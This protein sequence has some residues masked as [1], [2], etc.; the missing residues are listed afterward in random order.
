MA[1]FEVGSTTGRR[2]TVTAALAGLIGCVQ[3]G[4]DP[5]QSRVAIAE[6]TA[7]ADCPARWIIG[8][9]GSGESG[10]STE[11]ERM[12]STV[13]AYV[14]EVVADL[15]VEGTELLSLPYPAVP[16]GPDYFSSV[17]DGWIGLQAILRGRVSE[18]PEIRI[19]VVGYSQ[20][21]H[22]VNQALHHLER[23]DPGVLA[24]IRAALLIADPR[25]DA[26]TPYHL[27][28]T[29]EGD[30]AP[31]PQNGGILTSQRLPAAL[32]SRAVSFCISGDLVCDASDKGFALLIQAIFAPLHLGYEECCTRTPFRPI[33]GSAIAQALLEPPPNRAPRITADNPR[34]DA[35]VGEE[36]TN[37]GDVAD[38]DG[39]PVNLTASIGSL[40]VT[41]NR[42]TWTHTVADAG[43]LTVE[44]TGTDP[45][46]L[47]T[48]VSFTLNGTGE[49]NRPPVANA[50]PD[51]NIECS[52]HDGTPVTLNG[53][54]SNDPDGDA[55][56][57]T[58][59]GPFGT[60]TGSAPTVSLPNGS[61]T[62]TLTVTDEPGASATDTVV[63]TVAD[64]TPPEITSAVADRSSLWPPNH[65]MVPVTIAVTATDAC[66]PTVTCAITEVTSDEPVDGGGD[67]NTSPDWEITGD[68]TVDLRAERAGGGDGR[69][70]TIT[71][72]CSDDAGN[73]ATRGVEVAV[74]HNR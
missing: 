19:A 57:F 35:E 46:G 70:Y 8:A 33:L 13:A 50:G 23:V 34:V 62:I 47:S 49:T 18:C 24:N 31:A 52:G 58:W 15:P 6:P 45:D 7:A 65:R 3:P 71:V 64:T 69:V 67:G 41:G 54:D 59:T 38:P 12:G 27:P 43:P 72:G 56:T 16:V 51:E 29:L 20:G 28:I 37:S 68:L 42:W 32:D 39:N 53:T 10:G 14:E 11:L 36:A 22:V 2:V 55:L 40:S 60:A 63:M 66:S 48:T 4:S 25:A 1:L 61:H 5:E 44:I 17:D 74:P 30:P 21:A 26:S 73:T 9:R